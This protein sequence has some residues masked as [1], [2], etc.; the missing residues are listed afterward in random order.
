MSERE[1]AAHWLTIHDDLLRGMTHALSNRVATIMAA[2]TLLELTGS[3]SQTSA[4]LRSESERLE[5]LLHTMRQLP[6]RR[7]QPLEPIM[8]EDIVR[9]A[10]GMHEHHPDGREAACTVHLEGDVQP[11]WAEPGDLQLAIAAALGSAKR[12]AGAAGSAVVRVRS[13]DDVVRIDVR[14]ECDDATDG[15]GEI[16][17]ASMRD[18]EAA[19]WLLEGSAGSAIA[20]ANGI[21]VTIPTLGAARRARGR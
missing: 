1:G 20:H 16:A 10:I 7:G 3:S 2:A 13:T 18:A 14:V 21:V 8:P 6:R 17:D 5:T 4:T 15:S 9:A 11:A 19:S 12:L